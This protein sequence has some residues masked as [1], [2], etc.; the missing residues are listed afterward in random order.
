MRRSRV[1]V[2][3]VLC[4][5]LGTTFLVSVPASGAQS[6]GASFVR[7]GLNY[8]DLDQY[9]A[10]GGDDA[11]VDARAL[12][13]I[14]GPGAEP[15][16]ERHTLDA[17][18]GT[19]GDQDWF[20]FTVT[21]ADITNRRAF[22][23]EAATYDNSTDTVIEVYGPGLAFTPNDPA[24]GFDYA[25][26]AA[27]NDDGDFMFRGS[28][29]AFLPY[30]SG[31]AGTYRF[32]IRPYS[33]GGVYAGCAGPYTL[34]IKK[35]TL[36][37]I[38]GDSR[39]DTAILV[40]KEYIRTYP[41]ASQN[42]AVVLAN[43]YNFPDALSGAVLSGISYGPLLLTP[44]DHLPSAV[45]NEI[46]RTG[47]NRVYVLGSEDSV[48][49]AVVSAIQAMSPAPTV[50][51]VEGDD[52]YHTAAEIALQAQS[53]DVIYGLP[54]SNLA[55]IASGENFPDA[56]AASALSARARTPILLT[57]Q[58]R[59]NS[60]AREALLHLGTTDVVVLGGP[61]SVS[62][63][64]TDR[65]ANVLGGSLHV[66]RVAGDSRYETAKLFATW[67]CDLRGPGSRGDGFIGTRAN[68]SIAVG[69]DHRT[70]GIA[71]GEDFPDGLTGGVMCGLRGAG[72]LLLNPST[73]VSDYIFEE[74][75]GKL[76]G[77]DT[78]YFTDIGGQAILTS[79][80]F[81]GEPTISKGAYQGL[82]QFFGFSSP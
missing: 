9:E 41:Q 67:A 39:I 55:I 74:H 61:A 5:A 25:N 59:L 77:S 53:D 10:G 2:S 82:D 73:S 46:A 7:P 4:L 45:R 78:D 26:A 63:A 34:R 47:V 35:G 71:S 60:D 69:L 36:L 27:V 17:A 13:T 66:Y 51:R 24:T 80:L 31:G 20:S 75:D 21:T 28:S 30:Q 48:G 58:H 32:R 37:R 65:L 22:L 19:T 23:I 57:E 11:K 68:T 40:S 29:I 44:Q 72:P 50:I 56:L 38:A 8:Y 6:G 18:T 79:R 12:G 54:I 14:P 16:T 62:T 42:R 70:V 76:P 3:I 52:R 15:K 33:T 43:A 49:P 64:V 81:G 1:W